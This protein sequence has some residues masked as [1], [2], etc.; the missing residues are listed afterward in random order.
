M[1]SVKIFKFNAKNDIT[2]HYKPFIFDNFNFL[3]LNE[4]LKATKEQDPYLDF[5]DLKYVKVNGMIAPLSWN[6]KDIMPHNNKLVIE[7]LS[8]RRAVKDLIIDT[9]DFKDSFER[10]AKFCNDEDRVE[11][12]EL[13]PYFYAGYIR[14]FE[15]SF[16]GC[17]GIIFAK[18]LCEK[19]PQRQDEILNVVKDDIFIAETYLDGYIC[20]SDEIYKEALKWLKDRLPLPGISK[21]ES[22]FYRVKFKPQNLDQNKIK[23]DFNGFNI[24]F[25]GDSKTKNAMNLKAKFI[26]L[27]SMSLPCGFNL[28]KFNK[29]LAI[30]IASKIVFDALDNGADFM[31]VDSMEA[32]Y[33]FDSLSKELQKV[34]CR[35]L[36]NFFILKLDEFYAISCGEMPQDLKIHRLKV[37]L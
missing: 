28:L 37:T 25:Y 30:K 3:S 23:H 5:K 15:P 9:S 6:F 27:D 33:M 26:K 14:E 20:W 35:E 24:A 10:F 12:N 34:A 21:F 11:F 16:M 29:P 8:I 31:L 13:L 1:L 17:S 4:L 22:E 18:Y 32:F 19:Y 2:S 7:P 36:D